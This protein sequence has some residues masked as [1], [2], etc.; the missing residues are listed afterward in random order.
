MLIGNKQSAIAA[1]TTF[2]SSRIRHTQPA[3]ALSSPLSSSL[4]L[5]YRLSKGHRCPA[6]SMVA[7][8][9]VPASASPAVVERTSVRSRPFHASLQL[10]LSAHCTRLYGITRSSTISETTAWILAV[11]LRVFTIHG[12]ASACGR[13]AMRRSWPIVVPEAFFAS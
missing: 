2:L 8:A 7:T 5:R 10:S 11:V 13:S 4:L 3:V 9:C 1:H 6:N 12:I